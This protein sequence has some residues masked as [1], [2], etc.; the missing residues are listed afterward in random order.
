M[1]RETIPY[2]KIVLNWYLILRNKNAYKNTDAFVI[3]IESF[4]NVFIKETR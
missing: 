2:S 3:V 4:K 1:G